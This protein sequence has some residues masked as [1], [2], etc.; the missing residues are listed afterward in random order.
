MK[1]EEKR[2]NSKFNLNYFVVSFEHYLINVSLWNI[3]L[4]ILRDNVV[5]F[6]DY[7]NNEWAYLIYLKSYD[8][9]EYSEETKR[10]IS[11]IMM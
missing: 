10:E 8:F 5:E 6:D 4:H 7:P 1:S 11:I 2:M 9:E 3:L